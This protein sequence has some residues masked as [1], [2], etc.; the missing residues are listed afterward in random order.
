MAWSTAKKNRA[1][2]RAAS[3]GQLQNFLVGW[4]NPAMV[5]GAVVVAGAVAVGWVEALPL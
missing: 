2:D 5:A 1:R 4:C 3:L